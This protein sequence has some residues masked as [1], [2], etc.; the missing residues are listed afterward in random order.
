[1]LADDDL[2]EA[3]RVAPATVAMLTE[4]APRVTARDPGLAELGT[5]VEH[6]RQEI[7]DASRSR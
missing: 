3:G 4:L 7:Q 6:L 5:A 1:L 2:A